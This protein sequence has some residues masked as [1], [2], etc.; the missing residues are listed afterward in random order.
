MRMRRKGGE[1]GG[2]QN[3]KT[4]FNLHI[5]YFYQMLCVLPDVAVMLLSWLPLTTPYTVAPVA[6]TPTMIPTASGNTPKAN[7]RT[8]DVGTSASANCEVSPEAT[9]L[10]IF[11]FRFFCNSFK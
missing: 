7:A 8:L 11:S 6:Q 4:H 10:A 3:V 5:L 9:N 2:G 1:G